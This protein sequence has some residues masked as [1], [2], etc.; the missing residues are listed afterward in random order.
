[1]DTGTSSLSFTRPAAANGAAAG[2]TIT[3]KQNPSAA[4]GRTTSGPLIIALH[5]GTYTSD[6]FDIPGHSLL[7]LAES[8]GVPVIALD[9]P[10]YGG[11]TPLEDSDSIIAKN[12]VVLDAVIADIW[13]EWSR[14]ASGVFLIGHSIGGAIVTDIAG[15]HPAWPLKGIAI[16]GCLLTVPPESADQWESLPPIPMIDLPTPMKDQ[17]MFGPAGSFG[18]DM[19]AASYPSNAPCPR[20]ELIDITSTWIA[21][22][23]EVAARVNVPVHSRQAE[24]DHLWV[25]DVDQVAQFAAAF[26]NSPSVDAKLEPGAGHCIDFHLAGPAFQAGQLA[27]AAMQ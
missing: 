6:Y 19:P 2:I 8:Q 24:F 14:T 3:G 9:R 17:V 26:T 27:F 5:G 12:A 21:R 15:N 18:A 10:A 23:R 16:S 20:A 25:T 7:E 4:G 1:M 13:N 22:V 11:S